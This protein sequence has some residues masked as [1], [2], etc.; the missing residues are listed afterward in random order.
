MG[1]R[2]IVD[3][4]SLYA[5]ND[6]TLDHYLELLAIISANDNWIF[7]EALANFHDSFIFYDCKELTYKFYC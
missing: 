5:Y 4:D 1:K 7:L 2:F 3:E 6:E